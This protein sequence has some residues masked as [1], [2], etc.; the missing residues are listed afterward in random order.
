MTVI[1]FEMVSLLLVENNS[2]IYS[3]TNDEQR[4]SLVVQKTNN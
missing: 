3:I 2:E 4:T 1:R